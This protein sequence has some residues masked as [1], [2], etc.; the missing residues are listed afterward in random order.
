MFFILVGGSA[1]FSSE[2]FLLRAVLRYWWVWGAF[3]VVLFP[4]TRWVC[5]LLG[6]LGMVCVSCRLSFSWPSLVLF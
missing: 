2:V 6:F 4:V 5:V 3:L 1:G